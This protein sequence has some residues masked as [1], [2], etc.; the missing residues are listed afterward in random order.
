MENKNKL[1][2]NIISDSDTWMNGWIQDLRQA[3]NFFGHQV[4]WVHSQDDMHKGD[5]CFILGY[6]EVLDVKALSKS[7]HNLVVHESDLPYGRGWSPLSW[8][9]LEGKKT[10]PITL[11][12]AEALVDRG[13]IY[14]Q[15]SMQLHG[16]ELVDELRSKQAIIT[17]ELC[18]KFV[19]EYPEILNHGKSQ[20][21]KS[22]Y[23]PKRTPT[24]SKLDPNK[25]I[26]EQF[27]LLRIADN[28]KYPIFFDWKGCR[29]LLKV[30]KI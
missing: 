17:I 24:D 21:G 30:E 18:K 29:Y 8:Q 15:D 2:I 19:M 5:L 23:F 16:N 22:S 14:L 25:T 26:A 20:K 7:K 1:L 12:E 13:V 27:N 3:L 6:G 4:C 11:F 28:E 10:I 9:I